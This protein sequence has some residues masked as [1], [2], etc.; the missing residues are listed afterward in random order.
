ML[1]LTL[2]AVLDRLETG[3][4]LL[5]RSLFIFYP[6]IVF[7]KLRVEESCILLLLLVDDRTHLLENRVVFLVKRRLIQAEVLVV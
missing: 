6:I 5:E 7:L 1:Q 3:A 2:E 4:E